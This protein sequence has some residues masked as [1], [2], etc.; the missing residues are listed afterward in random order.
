ML[1]SHNFHAMTALHEVI[2][3]PREFCILSAGA[4][5]S[6]G[7]A[8]TKTNGET[9]HF[10]GRRFSRLEIR[11]PNQNKQHK[12][13]ILSADAFQHLARR[14]NQNQMTLFGARAFG[15]KSQN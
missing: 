12:L 8:K 9:L 10:V 11:R 14:H 1:N 3:R 13:Y 6:P 5:L 4:F 2:N 7:R 15:F